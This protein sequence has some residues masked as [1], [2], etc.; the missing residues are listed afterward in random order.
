MAIFL[1]NAGLPLPGELVLLAFGVAA[2]REGVSI[3]WGFA[4]A[5]LGAMAG[6]TVSYWLGRWAGLRMLR[7]YCRATLGSGQCV[8]S[9]R[10]FYHRFGRLAVVLGPI[11][12]RDSGPS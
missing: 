10:A 6:D 12:V 1:H 7:A 9:A 2:R 5:G 8:A 11:R 4:A 3:A